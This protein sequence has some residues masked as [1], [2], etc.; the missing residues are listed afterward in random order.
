MS[1]T[2]E[3]IA[4]TTSALSLLALLWLVIRKARKGDQTLENSEAAVRHFLS[5]KHKEEP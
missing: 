2:I 4:A 5:P 3:L 1:S